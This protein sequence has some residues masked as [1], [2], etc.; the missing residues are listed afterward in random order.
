MIA[1]Q[2]AEMP[3]WLVFAGYACIVICLWLL[4]AAYRAY[5]ALPPKIVVHFGID[6]QPDGWGPRWMI[7]LLPALYL[8]MIAML[9]LVLQNPALFKTKTPHPESEF[10]RAQAILRMIFLGTGVLF[11]VILQAMIRNSKLPQNT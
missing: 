11:V 3:W 8:C 6:L 5:T 4:I 2:L 7:Y 1:S 10:V 9:F